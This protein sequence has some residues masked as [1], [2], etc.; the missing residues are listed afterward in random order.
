MAFYKIDAI[1]KP[2]KTAGNDRRRAASRQ[3]KNRQPPSEPHTFST[4]NGLL[5]SLLL[6]FFHDLV[7]FG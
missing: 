2:G 6:C 4:V 7:S 3:N 1:A 5:Y